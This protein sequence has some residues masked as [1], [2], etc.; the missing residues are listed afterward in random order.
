MTKEYHFD[1]EKLDALRSIVTQWLCSKNSRSVEDSVRDFAVA[2][3]EEL[4]DD[5]EREDGEIGTS[6]P[7]I[8]IY[9][10]HQ[11]ICE[12][13]CPVCECR[14]PVA[15]YAIHPEDEDDACQACDLSELG[16]DLE[17]T[18]LHYNYHFQLKHSNRQA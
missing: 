17:H 10:P 15:A 2:L 3:L 4:E 5:E 6:L 9:C 13:I 18:L 14:F 11:H 12:F 16:S 1:E 8:I 7:A